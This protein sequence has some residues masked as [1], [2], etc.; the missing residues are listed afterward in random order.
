MPETVASLLPPRQ[1][2][3]TPTVGDLLG[4]LFAVP[5]RPPGPPVPLADVPPESTFDKGLQF[6]LG[7]LGLPAGYDTSRRYDPHVAGELLGMA[8]PLGIGA[9]NELRA[10]VNEL[11]AAK[12][13]K[14][15]HGSPHDFDA[16]STAKIGTGEGAQ[17]YGHGLY[18]A[19]NEGTARS[20]RDSL[21]HG[22]QLTVRLPNGQVL[23]GDAIDDIGLDATRFL[24]IGRHDAGQF[25]HNT[26]YY[27]KRAAD[28]AASGLKGA[29]A[30]NE[31]VKARIDE[32]AGARV[33]YEPIKGRMYEVNINADPAH[34]LD[35]EKPL[36]QQSQRVQDAVHQA[37]VNAGQPVTHTGWDAVFEGDTEP[38]QK[39]AR[40]RDARQYIKDVRAAGGRIFP[41]RGFRGQTGQT[42][43]ETLGE[44]VGNEAASAA[45]RQ[46]GVPGLKYLDQGSRA[47]GRGT[48]NLV[49]FDDNLVTI[50]KKYGIALPVIEGL[51]RQAAQQGGVVDLSGVR[52]PS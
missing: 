8:L 40:A 43:Y 26:T 19:E 23:A 41:R 13:I 32:W 37:Y 4:R 17:S 49:V 6:F 15:F 10:A 42:A 36:H 52:G 22:D 48:Y 1:T 45:L 47:A 21:A 24:E 46:S 38:F 2:T 39:F 20:Y 31:A 11:K 35:L 3:K 34:L 9:G 25:P 12:G 27:A 5:Q 50:L 28:R 51:R 30:R 29:A 33:G 16:F 7:A 18:F 14:A 44:A